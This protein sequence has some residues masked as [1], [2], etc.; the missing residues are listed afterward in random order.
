LTWSKQISP[1]AIFFAQFKNLI[2][3][4]LIVAGVVSGLLG[5]GVDAIA[6]LSIVVLNAV[7]GFYQ[8]YNAEKS[9]VALRKMTA[10]RA[11]VL[12]DGNVTVVPSAEVV[13]GDM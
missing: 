6:V 7:I 12:R 11:K 10:P 5:E 8:E 1:W 13:P 4:L 2:V 3:W 9:I